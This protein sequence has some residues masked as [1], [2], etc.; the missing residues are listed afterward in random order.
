AVSFQVVSAIVPDSVLVQTDDVS[1][2]R[3]DNAYIK[4]DN[5]EGYRYVG[6]IP[7]SMLQ[8]DRVRYTATVYVEGKKYTFPQETSGAPLDWD[9]AIDTYWTTEIIDRTEPIVLVQSLTAQPEWET[10]AI[11]ETAHSRV[12]KTQRDPMTAPMWSYTFTGQD[13]D[14]KFFWLRDIKQVIAERKYKIDE[15]K[16]LIVSVANQSVG[17]EIQ[18]GFVSNM[19]YTYA[20]TVELE[21]DSPQQVLRI[22]LEALS[23]VPTALL[24]APYPTFL[25][26]YFV[27][28]TPIPF[29]VRDCEKLI[30]S[31]EGAIDRD[32]T[33]TI[34]A[35]WM[36]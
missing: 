18:I 27:P 12:R 9:A 13:S 22:P 15:V 6:R 14:T 30:I 7:E 2:W 29:G 25:E 23:L 8:G 3:D 32:A 35:I 4:L 24:P 16:S 19:G 11:P 31:T 33:I 21:K 1:F 26:R 20:A 28:V 34:G 10:Y 5:R 17:G 36:E